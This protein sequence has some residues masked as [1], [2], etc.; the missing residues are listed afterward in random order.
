MQAMQYGNLPKSSAH[1]G[2]I[3]AK[4]SAGKGILVNSGGRDSVSA[5]GAICMFGLQILHPIQRYTTAKIFTMKAM[6]DSEAL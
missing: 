3:S 2:I 1:S 6:I 4:L 5:L